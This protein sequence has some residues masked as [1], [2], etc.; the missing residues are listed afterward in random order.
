M[1]KTSGKKRIRK[2]RRGRTAPERIASSGGG[3]SAGAPGRGRTAPERATS[4]GANAPTVPPLAWAG[5]VARPGALAALALGLLVIGSYFP[6]FFA[7]FV[8]DDEAFTEAA[9]VR[10]VSGLWRIWSSPRAI[11]NEGHYWPLVYTTFWLEHKLWGFAPA[12]YHAVNG[13]AAPRQHAA[14][15]AP[16]R[17]AGRARR[18][19]PRRGVRR[20]S[21]ARRVRRLGDRAQG[22]A[23]G[24]CST[25]PRSW[26][27]FDS[28]RNGGRTRAEASPPQEAL[29]PAETLPSGRGTALP[30][31]AAFRRGAISWRWRCSCS[32][33]SASPSR[34]RCL[35]RC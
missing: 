3:T 17:S 25:S 22:S 21:P 4:P 24:A 7:G 33:C 28:W 9:A 27:G 13:R 18:V 23:L 16:R 19:A 15:L 6:A 10:E 12:G 20:P 31:G 11:E 34:P 32:R 14:S 35:R 1:G 30:E 26:P 2:A 29:L 8:W 5:G